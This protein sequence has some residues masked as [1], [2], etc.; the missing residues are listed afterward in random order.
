M[1]NLIKNLFNKKFKKFN[2]EIEVMQF[3]SYPWTWGRA[4]SIN[5]AWN[6][7]KK[8]KKLCSERK[9]FEVEITFFV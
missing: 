3:R 8:F 7:R 6:F 2:A 4:I 5:M 9:L 1:I